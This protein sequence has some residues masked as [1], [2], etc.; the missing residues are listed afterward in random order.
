MNNIIVFTLCSNNYLAHA[1][2]LCESVKKF[3]PEI[4]TIIGLV[5]QV[6]PS[7]DY[8]LFAGTEILQ[9]QQLGFPVV[10]QMALKYNIIEFNTAV[11]PY[12][13][14][15]LFRRYSDQAVIYYLDPDIE[16]FSDFGEMNAM[17]LNHE[18]LI[19]PHLAYPFERISPFEVQVLRVGVFN[20]GFIGLRK[21]KIV[22]EFLVWWKIRLEKFCY[23]DGS[24]GLFV[25]QKWVN[26]VPVLFNGVHIIKSPSYN[27]G[28]WNFHERKLL[29][30]YGRYC[31]NEVKYPL[32][33]FHF[34][35]FK[36][37][38]LR[39][40]C[41]MKLPEFTFSERPDL[42]EIF[43]NYARNLEANGYTRF[44]GVKPGIKFGKSKFTLRQRIGN[45]IKFRVNSYI[46]K[47]FGV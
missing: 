28:C 1:K 36:P 40:F 8:S 43:C 27:M 6:D 25:D 2:T 14:E 3:N 12:Y 34:S 29:V 37:T 42:Q 24:K 46:R 39:Y 26:L 41:K 38:D 20:L 44:S 10:D 17:L 31:V 30:A 4:E 18:I 21:S 45:T 23:N 13:F 32:V 19:T 35:G 16:V 7:I 9:Y 47:I 22:E 5:D 15:C 33:F 11:K